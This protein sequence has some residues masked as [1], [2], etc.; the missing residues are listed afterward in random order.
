MGL[1][2]VMRR[3]GLALFLCLLFVATLE[4]CTRVE[5]W[6][7]W[8]AP[9]WGPYSSE[10]LRTTDEIGTRNRPG[11]RFEK[12]VINSAG[13]R[14]PELRVEK[15]PGVVRVGVAGA[16]EVFGLYESPDKDVTA[17]LRQQLSASA[18]GRFEVVNL[19]SAGI[20][21]PRMRELFERWAGRFQFD[22]VVLYPTPAF[23][24]DI[25]PPNRVSRRPS[26]ADAVV[27]SRFSARLPDKLWRALRETL[28]ARL[29]TAMKHS[30]VER[31]RR[32]HAPGWV[33]NA[34]PRERVELFATDMAELVDV[35]TRTGATV[36]LAT[37]ANR[38]PSPPRTEDAAQMLGWVRFYPRASPE[39]LIDMEQKAEEAIRRLGSERGLAVVDVQAA[40][41][42][43]PRYYADFS[44][45]TDAGAARAAEALAGPIESLARHERRAAN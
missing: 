41:G 35:V 44:H 3:A 6:W 38:F 20:T 15:A 39:C 37:H 18:P 30:E 11:A 21:P 16:S 7:R 2:A 5:A 40:L 43:D 17:Q 23:Y 4:V 12:W 10:I 1:G 32:A 45:F 29:Q 19:A 9:F 34:A 14:G 13:F 42:K 28:P 26:A 33:W 22:V 27:T 36:M 8:D 31:V 24:L 25:E